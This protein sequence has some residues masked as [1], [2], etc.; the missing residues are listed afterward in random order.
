MQSTNAPVSGGRQAVKE[1]LHE[2]MF[3]EAVVSLEKHHSLYEASFDRTLRTRKTRKCAFLEQ[4]ELV[5]PW[6]ALVE[7]IVPVYP[8]GRTGRPP[9]SLGAMLRTHF[10][11]QWFTSS[12]LA[13]QEA[14]FDAPIYREFAQ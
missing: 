11:Q 3:C 4:M 8:E 7:M 6:G 2:P 10:M 1:I 14:F 9:F 12:D 5:I 13:M